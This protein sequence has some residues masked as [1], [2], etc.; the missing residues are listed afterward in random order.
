MDKI[1]RFPN[2]FVLE[3]R[4]R[5][6][7]VGAYADTDLEKEFELPHIEALLKWLTPMKGVSGIQEIAIRQKTT[8]ELED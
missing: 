2:G 4:Y 7:D 5:D 6:G 1:E 3:Y 8:D